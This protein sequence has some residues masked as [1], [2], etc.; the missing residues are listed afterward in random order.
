MVASQATAAVVVA[1]G[2]QAATLAQQIYAT[3]VY[4][5]LAERPLE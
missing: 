2:I 3:K 5:G 1:F 4:W